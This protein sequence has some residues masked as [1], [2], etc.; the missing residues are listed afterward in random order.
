MSSSVEILEN[1]ATEEV[2]E[3]APTVEVVKVSPKKLEA[4]R[5]NAQRSTGPRTEAGKDRS[6]R[7]ALKHGVLASDVLI[8]SGTGA[9]D[10]HRF[11][12]LLGELFDD[13]EPVGT[14]EEMLVEK[15]AV[16]W[17]RQKRACVARLE[18]LNEHSCPPLP[19]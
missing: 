15:I 11:E 17:W 12:T 18:W 13:L 4:N 7:N 2:R 16:C 6:R 8:K 19:N 10:A 5:R 3:N 1:E 14:F 9:E